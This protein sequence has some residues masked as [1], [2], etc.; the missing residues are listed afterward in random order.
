MKIFKNRKS[1]VLITILLIGCFLIVGC[2]S[3]TS[4][5]KASLPEK[6]EE[7]SAQDIQA[8]AG[9]E[10]AADSETE[11]SDSKT[12]PTDSKPNAPVTDGGQGHSKTINE[13]AQPKADSSKE[14]TSENK[15]VSGEKQDKLDATEDI[16]SVTLSIVGPEDI[17]IILK[18]T[19]VK[20]EEGETVLDVLKKAA[21]EN[22]IPISVRGRKSAAYVEGI[23]NLF[24]FDR[25]AK[26][27]WVYRVNGG[28]S[29]KSAGAFTVKAGDVIEWIYT[30]DLGRDVGDVSADPGGAP[31]E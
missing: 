3:K 4:H 31:D 6:G 5:S 7:L 29:N 21:Q 1:L 12:G 14:S 30:L 28:L 13:M 17:G 26:S 16:P 20:I 11:I 9:G 19:E 15:D 27:G 24:E 8:Q 10:R 18:Q 2:G 25:G 23:D 22:N